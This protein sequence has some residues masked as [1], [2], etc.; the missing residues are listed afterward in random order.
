VAVWFATS[1]SSRA[2][3]LQVPAAPALSR[4]PFAHLLLLPDQETRPLL[5]FLPFPSTSVS[6][7]SRCQASICDARS[8]CSRWQLPGEGALTLFPFSQHYSTTP[9]PPST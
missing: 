6:C 1:F 7:A 4:S 5:L 3:S 9:F 8:P 2:S